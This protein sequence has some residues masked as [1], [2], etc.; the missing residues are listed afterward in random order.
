MRMMQR[1][2]ISEVLKS[3]KESEDIQLVLVKRGVE[4]EQLA[5]ILKMVNDRGI[6]IIRG[7]DN[8]IWRMSRDNSE[9]TPEILALV[10]RDPTLDLDESIE[11]GGLIWLLAGAA[12]PVNIGFCIRT[13]EVSGADAVIVD[14]ELSNTERKAAKRASMKAH[15]FIPV[16]WGDGLQ[17]VKKAKDSGFRIISVEDTGTKYPWEADLT[18]NIVLIVGGEKKGISREILEYSDEVIRIPMTGFVPSFNLQAPLSAVAIE[19][20]KQRSPQNRGPQ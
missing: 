6:R 16:H 1:C 20:Q 4:S 11:A 2:G 3:L 17:A 12:Y 5:G 13:A 8:D 14:A 19:A 18:G 7:S 9:G 10:G 15:R